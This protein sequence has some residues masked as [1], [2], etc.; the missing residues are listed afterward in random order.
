MGGECQICGYK[1]DGK[2]QAAFDFH[3]RDSDTK[4]FNISKISKSSL[5][6]E[7]ML[8]ESEKCDVLCAVCHRLTH[9][10]YYG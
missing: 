4:E 5:T 1:F 10:G 7:R 8:K 3:H 2:N 6:K 9:S